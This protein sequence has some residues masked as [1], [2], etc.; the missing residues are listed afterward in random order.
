MGW[1]TLN[2]V[3]S[4]GSFLFAVGVLLFLVNFVRSLRSGAP[5]GANPWNAG[6]LEWSVPSPPP[7]FNFVVIPQVRSR[8]P[9]WERELGDTGAE[10]SLKEGM[11][12]DHG[13]ETVGTSALDAD[14]DII[15]RMPGDS[16]A[17]FLL[18]VA[19]AV[20]F[21]GL[22]LHS[23]WIAAAGALACLAALLAWCWP[24]AQLLQKEPA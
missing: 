10:T 9:L 4:V 19:A 18:S 20:L 11:L 1:N 17:P 12:L 8:H 21:G 13:R 5:A 15:L 2:M 6:T 22:L 16:L 23:W 24:R 3:T 7:A 14:P